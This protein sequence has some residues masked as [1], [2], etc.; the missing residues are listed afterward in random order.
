METQLRIIPLKDCDTEDPKLRT[1]IDRLL[2]GP[3]SVI[4]YHPIYIIANSEQ[5]FLLEADDMIVGFCSIYN[6]DNKVVLNEFEIFQEFR[7]YGYGKKFAKYIFATINPDEFYE[8]MS[9]AFLFWWKV[10]G[11]IYFV[12]H[13]ASVI[14]AQSV[15]S[16]DEKKE[17]YETWMIKYKHKDQLNTAMAFNLIARTLI[18]N[19]LTPFEEIKVSVEDSAWFRG[20]LVGKRPDTPRPMDNFTI[21]LHEN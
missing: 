13:I 5:Y 10:L 12:Q 11:G 17:I 2:H 15:K 6:E 16:K 20:I 21:G 4:G 7:Q 19:P 1:A 14:D 18:E 9:S 8:M 3:I